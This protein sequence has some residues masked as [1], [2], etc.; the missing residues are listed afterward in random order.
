MNVE[1]TTS[2][3]AGAE[4]SRPARN[5]AQLQMQDFFKI[6]TAQLTTQDPLK[7]VDNQDFISQMAT[8]SSLQQMEMLSTDFSGFRKEQ[9]FLSSQNLIG[10]FIRAET[11]EGGLIE[12]R[13]SRVERQDG[14]MVPFVGD[15]ATDFEWITLIREPDGGGE[16]PLDDTHANH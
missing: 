16:E 5:Q 11:P 9:Q 12:G 10:K 13:V 4:N 1:A 15:V 3:A 2:Y 8:F 6:L 14:R 7:P